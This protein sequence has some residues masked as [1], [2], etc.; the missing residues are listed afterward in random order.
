[1]AESWTA[2][3]ELTSE[4]LAVLKLCKKQ[5]LW[6]FLRRHHHVIMDEEI[7]EALRAMYPTEGPGRPP[8]APEM[9]AVAMLL[10]VGFGVADHE[11]PTLT[12]VDA[13][14]QMV[15]GCGRRTEPA[16]SQG[17]VFNF[18]ERARQHG[19]M[20]RLLDKTVAVARESGGFDHKRMRAIID[21]SPLVGAGRVEDTFNLLGRAIRELIDVASAESGRDAAELAQQLDVSVAL[22]KSTKAVLDIDWRQPAARVRALTDLIAQFDS[23]RHWLRDQ[24]DAAAL[25]APPLSECIATVERIIEQDTDPSPPEGSSAAETSDIRDGVAKDRLVSLSDRDMRHGRKSRSKAF[26]GYKRHVGVDADVPGLI[27]AV[28]VLPANRPEQEAAEPLLQRIGARYDVVELHIDRGYLAAEVVIDLHERGVEV[29]T[30]PPQ[31]HNGDRFT[32][33]DFKIDFA[34]NTVECPAGAV[35]PVRTNLAIFPAATCRTCAI[36]GQCITEKNSRGR[37]VRL[38]PQERW[39]R[40]MG[41]ELATPDGRARRRE[42]TRVEHDLARVGALQGT[43]ARYRGLAKNQAHLEAVATVNNVYVIG[44]LLAEAA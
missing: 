43:K 35:T 19:L 11:V 2:R 16:F 10:Q 7:R 8:V 40:T 28:E 24:F 39:Y 30:K 22:G 25:E 9:L 38:H 20:R 15:L 32:K 12:V 29:I 3:P 1:M 5:K 36:R 37:V 23:I 4:D 6:N 27:A 41:E 14:W 31:P 44:R 13:R 18:R 33:S 26:V 21:S 17:T 42:R 34:A